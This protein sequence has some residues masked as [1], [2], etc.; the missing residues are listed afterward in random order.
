[1]SFFASILK[2]FKPRHTMSE[3]RLKFISI[4]EYGERSGRRSRQRLD[5]CGYRMS[6]PS[7]YAM[8]AQMEDEGLIEGWYKCKMI[9]EYQVKELFHKITDKG[10]EELKRSRE[11]AAK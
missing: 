3:K 6:G 5:Q 4:L 10:I 1:M 11:D 8:A 2:Y 9:E 7:F